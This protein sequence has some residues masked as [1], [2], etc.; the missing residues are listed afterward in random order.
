MAG[1]SKALTE[2]TRHV[3]GQMVHS[4]FVPLYFAS[5]AL[6]YDFLAEFDWFIVLFVTV[7]SIGAKFLGAYVGAWSAGMSRRDRRSIG[8]A[9][10]PSGV[11]GIVVADVALELGILTT[12][13]FVAIVVSVISSSLLVSS[14]LSWSTG[15]AESLSLL[16]FLQRKATVLDLDVMS[17]G[18]VIERLCAGLELP[19]GT[20]LSPRACAEIVCAREAL[21]G[22]SVG[23]G[24]AFPHARLAGLTKPM[25]VFGRSLGGVEWDAPDGHRVHLVF[26][27]LSTEENYGRQ[28]QILAT[29]AKHCS[30]EG[31]RERLTNATSEEAV[32][33]ILQELRGRVGD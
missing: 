3:I 22:T 23:H 17:R 32:W 30:D 29:L 15:R 14:L 2:Q 7:I 20:G 9:F 13:V 26:L 10:T 31:F 1:Q 11:T 16:D 19:A 8:I 12:P 33:K 27:L 25:L 21:A 28:L 5:L 6:R 24:V 18:G 4:I